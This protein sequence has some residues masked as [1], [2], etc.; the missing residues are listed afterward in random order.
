MASFWYTEYK[1]H[2]TEIDLL[3][4][5]LKL[6]LFT[7]SFSPSALDE[8]FSDLA[9]EVVGSG[10]TAGGK[11]LSGRSIVSGVFDA[12]DVIWNPSSITARYA[13]LY[14]D[15]GDPSTSRLIR[16]Y[17][18]GAEKTSSSN[19]FVAQFDGAGIFTKTFT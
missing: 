1:N 8:F 12:N 2:D 16:C 9:N 15:T 13:V 6:A 4:D 17:D 18:P 5:D 11:S 14:H 19:S 10:Y 7:S 3:T